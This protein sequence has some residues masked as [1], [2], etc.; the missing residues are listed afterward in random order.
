MEVGGNY[1][2]TISDFPS[3]QRTKDLSPPEIREGEADS[4]RKHPSILLTDGRTLNFKKLDRKRVSFGKNTEFPISQISVVSQGDSEGV[5]EMRPM[6][7]KDDFEKYMEGPLNYQR[8]VNSLVSQALDS[9][10]Q[11]LFHLLSSTSQINDQL[12]SKLGIDC[13]QPSETQ[14]NELIASNSLRESHIL[15]LENR[16]SVLE[17]RLKADKS[18]HGYIEEQLMSKRQKTE[19]EIERK[20]KELE[21]RKEKMQAEVE[22]YKKLT[23]VSLL[24][25][26]GNVLTGVCRGLIG[27]E[28]KFELHLKRDQG[29]TYTPITLQL[30][31]MDEI[32]KHPVTHLA[33]CELL[34]IFRRMLS[35]ITYRPS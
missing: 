20:R 27:G 8:E 18:E 28:L 4:V 25:L 15:E 17:E 5:R 14:L 1:D 29:Y 35:A 6:P 24:Q 22:M 30:H 16:I 19:Q 23:G 33:D 32:L 12:A 31:G 9:I 11:N 34:M 10:N 13:R 21:A 3:V 2:S 26:S 7:V